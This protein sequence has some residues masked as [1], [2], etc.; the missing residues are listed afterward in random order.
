[1]TQKEQSVLSDTG[2]PIVIDP[3]NG[4]WSVSG[5]GTIRQ[6]GMEQALAMVKVASR[7]DLAK[8]GENLFRPLAETHPLAAGERRVASGYLELS[9]V[10]PTSEMVELIETSR[11]I[12]VNINLMQT[13][14]QMLGGLVNRVMR[15]S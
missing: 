5:Q 1:M 6:P 2:T 4:P 10:Q 14:D 8:S 15:T 11:A 12:E 9:G 13:Q 7:G 3:T